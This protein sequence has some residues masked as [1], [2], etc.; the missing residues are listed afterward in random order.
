MTNNFECSSIIFHA[1]CGCNLIVEFL[2]L[3]LHQVL[4]IWEQTIDL[5]LADALRAHFRHY[6]DNRMAA[7]KEFSVRL[8]KRVARHDNRLNG[9]LR[10]YGD[11]EWSLFERQK[12]SCDVDE[13]EIEKQ[14][15][16]FRWPQKKAIKISPD[17]FRVPSGKI[18]IFDWNQSTSGRGKK[19]FSISQS[20]RSG[21]NWFSY[22]SLVDG[23]RFSVHGTSRRGFVLSIDEESS[24]QPRG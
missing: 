7:T 19:M 8:Q 13:E 5:V 12:G 23:F 11:V 16:A 21:F 22:L 24:P 17:W 6:R 4:H 9:T 2:E 18:N 15:K 3:F 10:L 20:H 1:R 14:V